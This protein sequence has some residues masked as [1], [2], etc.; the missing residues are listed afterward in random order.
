MKHPEGIYM[1]KYSCD[2]IERAKKIKLL[3]LDVDG[4]LTDGRIV[5][6]NYGDEI[7]NFDVNDGLGITFVKRFGIKCVI[8]T[9]KASR[10]VVKRAKELRI[11]KVYQNFHYKIEALGKIRRKFHVTDEEICFVGDDVIDIPVLKRA[12]L[13]VAPSSAMDV[14]KPFTHLVTEKKGGRGAVREVCDL[15][16]KAQGKWEQLM[17]RYIE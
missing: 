4:V 13:A 6:G 2:I 15:I 7:K 1:D 10:V 5:Y 16:L 9:A 3:L 12:G 17:S 11:D 8:L 14:V